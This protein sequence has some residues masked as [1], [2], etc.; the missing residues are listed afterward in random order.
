MG[1]VGTWLRIGAEQSGPI[2]PEVE[3]TLA[4]LQAFLPPD[5]MEA[6]KVARSL[7]S[8]GLPTLKQ[9]M[10]G[11]GKKS[12]PAPQMDIGAEPE[13]PQQPVSDPV[14]TGMERGSWAESALKRLQDMRVTPI[15]TEEGK[16]KESGMINMSDS[17][18][19][20][21]DPETYRQAYR[22]VSDL[23]PIQEANNALDQYRQLV[24]MESQ[25]PIQA[26]WS[27]LVNWLNK[28]GDPRVA[29]VGPT[30]DPQA[31][32]KNLRAGLQ[33]YST[34]RTNLADKVND[35]IRA[36]KGGTDVS[37]MV[38][39]FELMHALSNKDP[40][41]KG[42]RKGLTAGQQDMA[43]DRLW[44]SFK[45]N[46]SA[47]KA[48]MAVQAIPDSITLLEQGASTTDEMLK[49]AL[50]NLVGDTRPSDRDVGAFGGDKRLLERA[51]Q[52]Y[53]SV[54]ATGSFTENNR[55]QL[56]KLIIGMSQV[57]T[58]RFSDVAKGYSRAAKNRIA[59]QGVPEDQVLNFLYSQAG[60][61]PGT[62]P[63]TAEKV[64][65]KDYKSERV[66]TNKDK[67]TGAT[68]AGP[69]FKDFLEQ[70]RKKKDGE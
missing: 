65:G 66:Q 10:P 70:R 37:K 27:P 4:G 32:L 61:D 12:K 64:G 60:F 13:L 33:T 41:A 56:R 67:R 20:L 55:E 43:W 38:E 3:Q 34:G 15:K 5:P 59:F 57:A 52:V 8:K 18:V 29:P 53:D 68:G 48:I 58:R 24:Q 2:T 26:D 7:A 42:G 35:Y 9:A 11:K 46:R 47:G 25:Q 49:R 36:M 63:K 21:I 50:L 22:T 23:P 51:K 54:I 44:N 62:L 16:I 14:A 31:Q 1:D 30:G 6:E 19:N 40:A 69:S 17:T 28:A 45:D 39:N